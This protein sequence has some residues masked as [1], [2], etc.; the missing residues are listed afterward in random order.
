[1]PSLGDEFRV[2]REARGLSLS[3]VAEQLHIRSTYLQAIEE[4]D[5]PAIGAPVYVR[6]FLRTYA[7]FLGIDPEHAIEAFGHTTASPSGSKQGS[8]A[9]PV[10]GV[11]RRG[12][13]SIWAWLATIVALGLIAYVGYGYY[14]LKI[15]TPPPAPAASTAAVP[16]AGG[17]TAV[18]TAAPAPTEGPRWTRNSV[19]V[20]L[21][22]LSWLRVVVDGKTALEGEFPPG[23]HREFMG[24]HVQVLA[25]NGGGVEVNAPGQPAR[26][27]GSPGQVVERDYVL[28]AKKVR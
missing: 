16:A 25:G 28:N 6:G 17:E 2:A 21:T 11:P 22:Q 24:R 1:M 14:Q 7:R 19:D 3:D 20:R 9:G 5:W 18:P 8:G 10:I 4:E 13:P 23:T 15:A 12:G 26:I 27:L